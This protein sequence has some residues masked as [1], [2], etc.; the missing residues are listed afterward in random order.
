MADTY[1]EMLD[2]LVDRMAKYDERAD[3]FRRN[4]IPKGHFYNVINPNKQTSSGNQYYA[5]I[6]WM[7]KLTR[8]SKDFCMIRK[9]SKDCGGIFISQE[10][11]K[12]LNDTAPEK[13]LSIL[14]K[15]V[16]TVKK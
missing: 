13:T 5:P 3:I 6:E 2:K 8:D 4:D 12:D 11:I 9:V 15:I 1:G 14:Q 7:V 10:D 16:G